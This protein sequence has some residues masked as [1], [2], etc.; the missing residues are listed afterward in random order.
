M[1][2]FGPG[3]L[4]TVVGPRYFRNIAATTLPFNFADLVS[5]MTEKHSL[6]RKVHHWQR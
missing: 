4:S 2:S 5:E 6:Y 3:E 1:L